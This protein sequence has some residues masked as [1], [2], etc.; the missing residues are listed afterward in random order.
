MRARFG[1][2]GRLAALAATA[3]ALGGIAG[4]SEAAAPGAP[5]PPPLAD[6]NEHA[7]VPIGAVDQAQLALLGV[8]RRG[9]R[10][11]DAVPDRTRDQ[12]AAALG[13]DVG[14]NA[15]LARHALRTALGEDLYVVPGRGWVCLTSTTAPASCV[16]T[17]RVAEGYGVALQRIPSGFRLGGLVPDGVAGVEVR[18]TAGETATATAEGN[19]WRADVAFEPAAVAWTRAGV[20][21]EVSVPV[22]APPAAPTAAAPE[23]PATPGP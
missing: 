8:L 16:P 17:E 13:P 14:A 21:G 20:D 15:G 7:A 4:V 2:A 19:A 3:V 11:D 18:G 1:S 22:T 9:G 10:P 5:E 12:V 23:R 6:P